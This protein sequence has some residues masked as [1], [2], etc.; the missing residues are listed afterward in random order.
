MPLSVSVADVFAEESFSVQHILNSHIWPGV[1]M[2][3]KVCTHTHTHTHIHMHVFCLLRAISAAHG[4]T[5][6]RGQI[7][8]TA[9]GLSHSN[10]E[11]E[12]CL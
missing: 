5:Q 10:K 2:I 11:S 4:G 8:A 12:P 6:A 3:Q 9:A 1:I 7:R